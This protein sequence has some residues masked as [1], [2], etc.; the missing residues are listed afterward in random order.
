[1]LRSKIICLQI[2]RTHEVSHDSDGSKVSASANGHG[3]RST[4]RLSQQISSRSRRGRLRR[5]RPRRQPRPN[6][7]RATRSRTRVRR[8]T[9]AGR[10]AFHGVQTSCI[11]GLR[12][13]PRTVASTGSSANGWSSAA[14]RLG[15]KGGCSES[16]PITGRQRITGRRDGHRPR[17]SRGGRRGFPRPR[18]GVGRCRRGGRIAA[19]SGRLRARG[20]TGRSRSRS[21]RRR[22]R[23][24]T[25]SSPRNSLRRSPRRTASRS[26]TRTRLDAPN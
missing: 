26:D 15:R 1:V 14:M 8:R 7:I 12:T 16:A 23:T 18:G 24:R 21:Q 6:R 13:R 2:Y 9:G 4:Y 19:R 25:N 10:A 20:G 5:G 22:F 3:A 11:S 17:F